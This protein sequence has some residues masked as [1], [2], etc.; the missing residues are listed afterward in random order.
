[1]AAIA[2]GDSTSECVHGHL[3]GSTQ[4]LCHLALCSELRCSMVA[5]SDSDRGRHVVEQIGAGFGGG[6]TG[7]RLRKS[8]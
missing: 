2:L 7:L 5:Q 3:S 8:K 6:Q 1:M 4:A